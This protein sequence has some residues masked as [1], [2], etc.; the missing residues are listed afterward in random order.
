MDQPK[1]VFYMPPRNPSKVLLD[2]PR[3]RPYMGP[4]PPTKEIPSIKPQN[5]EK[6]STSSIESTLVKPLTSKNSQR[7]L[8]EIDIFGHENISSATFAVKSSKQRI[9]HQPKSTVID[10]AKT[11][12]SQKIAAPIKPNPRAVHT[13]ENNQDLEKDAKVKSFYDN[14]KPISPIASPKRQIQIPPSKRSFSEM[15]CSQDSKT[16][17]NNSQPVASS[18]PLPKNHSESVLNING[19]FAERI[20]QQIYKVSGK[21]PNHA[22]PLDQQFKPFSPLFPNQ[23]RKIFVEDESTQ[24]YDNL[25]RSM[26][27]Y[28]KTISYKLSD[29]PCAKRPRRN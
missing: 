6:V 7:C 29:S 25:F 28:Q 8:K 27:E 13:I 1:R 21:S 3:I 2:R 19:C 16:S 23:P 11:I 15:N 20:S 17:A 10:K 18:M 22:K 14:P 24:M 12:L 5:P 4:L 26:L 9:Q